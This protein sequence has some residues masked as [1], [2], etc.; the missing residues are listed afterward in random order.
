MLYSCLLYSPF[1]DY[2]KYFNCLRKKTTKKNSRSLGYMH[3]LYSQKQKAITD[4]EEKCPC[5]FKSGPL[6]YKTSTYILDICIEHWMLVTSSTA[7]SKSEKKFA[8]KS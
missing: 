2:L 3:V 1:F 6:D 7:R 4:R 5:Y 8:T